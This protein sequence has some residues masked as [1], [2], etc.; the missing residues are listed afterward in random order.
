[1]LEKELQPV[2][3]DQGAT[4][5]S[6]TPP[7]AAE[8]SDSVVH[9]KRGRKSSLDLVQDDINAELA[10]DPTLTGRGLLSILMK[11]YP[12]RFRLTQRSSLHGRILAWRMDRLQVQSRKQNRVKAPI[13]KE[14]D[15]QKLQTMLKEQ[16]T[17]IMLFWRKYKAD[18]ESQS[19][20]LY[21]YS[22]FCRTLA[23]WQSKH[24]IGDGTAVDTTTPQGGPP[25]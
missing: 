16:T 25:L 22:Q 17:T 19:L 3:E 18:C 12:G 10:S 23:F 1:M 11:R 5:I 14:P 24:S 2:S 8:S 13:P 9:K 21:K 15:W 7:K 6:P 20:L 4:G